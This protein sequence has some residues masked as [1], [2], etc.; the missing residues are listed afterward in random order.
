MRIVI[1]RCDLCGCRA[2]LNNLRERYVFDNVSQVCGTCDDEVTSTQ[3]KIR[4]FYYDITIAMIV[5]YMRRKRLACKSTKKLEIAE[6]RNKKTAREALRVRIYDVLIY[7]G[8]GSFGG[9]LYATI[10]DA[11]NKL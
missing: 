8:A 4:S 5:K 3:A 1:G 10:S 9:I 2:S 11:I 7:M 6:D